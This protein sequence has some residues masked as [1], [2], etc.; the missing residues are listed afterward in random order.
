MNNLVVMPLIIP[1]ITG[2]VLVIFRRQIRL[3]RLM[4]L[5]ATLSVSVVAILLMNQ[6]VIDGPQTLQLGNWEAPFGIS[7]VADML[8]GILVLVTGIVVSCCLLYAFFSIGRDREL[9]YFY[10]LVL[11]LLTGINGSFLTGDIFN[12]FVCFEV[13]LVASYVLISLGGTKLQL[14]E[15]FKYILVNLISSFLFLVSIAY[16]YGMLGTLNM[17]HLSVRVAEA[18]QVG[19]LIPVA[20]LFLIVF[21]IKAGLLLFYWLPGSYSAP[22]TVVGAVFASLLT[23]VGAY[24]IIRVFSLIFHHDPQITYLLIGILAGLTMLL[25]A[26][27]AVAYWDIK[28]IL[29]YNVIIS[30][31]LILA[32]FASFNYAGLTGSVYYLIHDMVVKALIFLAGGTI[33]YVTGTSKIREISGLIQLHPQLGWMFFIGALSAEQ[34]PITLNSMCTV[35]AESE[36]IGLLTQG[37]AKG[38]IIAGLHQ[39]IARRIAGMAQRM[40]TLNKVTFTGGVARNEGVRANLEEQLGVPVLV[41]KDCQLA[42]AIGAALIAQDSLRA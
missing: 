24:A 26:I 5:L 20:I 23:K 9:N 21:S 12:L 39:S 30:I 14:R 2:L 40:G 35:F 37:R 22:P 17:A 34:T 19:L 15:S 1:L 27:G 29:T 25:G 16:L 36:V 8:S 31:G 3:H 33:I 42:G 28:R 18:G 10:P 11:F 41:P 7:L 6:V 13:M 38:E 32:G 4:S